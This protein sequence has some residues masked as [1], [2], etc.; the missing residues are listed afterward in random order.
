LLRRLALLLPG[1]ARYG[2]VFESATG[3][4]DRAKATEE[5][6][7]LSLLNPQA[8]SG[9]PAELAADGGRDGDATGW[10]DGYGGH[11]SYLGAYM[12]PDSGLPGR[13]YPGV[14]RV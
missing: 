1:H 7:T 6:S 11:V 14:L 8:R 12:M 4:G 3:P 2:V 10:G 9:L 13:A 5:E